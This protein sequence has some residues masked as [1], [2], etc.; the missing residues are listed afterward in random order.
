MPLSFLVSINEILHLRSMWKTNDRTKFWI[1]PNVCTSVILAF[2]TRIFHSW[3]V[4][5]C[6]FHVFLVLSLCLTKCEKLGLNYWALVSPA[7]CCVGSSYNTTLRCWNSGGKKSAVPFSDKLPWWHGN[8]PTS[9]YGCDHI[10]VNVSFLFHFSIQHVCIWKDSLH[11]YRWRV[12]DLKYT[13]LE[14]ISIHIAFLYMKDLWA[15]R[16]SCYYYFTC[17]CLFNVLVLVVFCCSSGLEC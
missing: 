15:I 6:V 10:F 7:S 14:R 16:F 1:M 3:S 2:C 12:Y 17:S 13:G 8:W 9:G 4:C 11:W 5:V